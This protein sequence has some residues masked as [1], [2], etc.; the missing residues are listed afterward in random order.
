MVLIDAVGFGLSEE[1][2][3]LQTGSSFLRI[4]SKSKSDISMSS[5]A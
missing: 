3:V 2:D 4:V 5:A 1:S